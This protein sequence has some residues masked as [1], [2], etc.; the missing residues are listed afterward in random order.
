MRKTGT[1]TYQMLLQFHIELLVGDIISCTLGII[2]QTK[3]LLHAHFHLAFP[4]L[5]NEFLD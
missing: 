2:E 5:C 4:L 3:P 1:L